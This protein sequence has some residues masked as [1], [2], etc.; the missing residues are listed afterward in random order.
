MELPKVPTDNLYKFMALSGIVLL[1]ASAFPRY[2]QA[3][4]EFELIRAQGE[5]R[6]GIKKKDWASAD[7][8][9][10]LTKS[11]KLKEETSKW[12]EAKDLAAAEPQLI[13]KKRQEIRT[14]AYEIKAV[15]T[16]IR[17]LYRD[18]EIAAIEVKTKEKE[19]S[20]RLDVIRRL[21]YVIAGG[22]WVGAILSVSGFLLWYHKLQKYQDKIVKKQA[23][24]N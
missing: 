13:E 3:K 8:D 18:S 14:D 12:K 10:L 5:K 1:V 2:W 23:T 11:N 4:L 16:E 20:Q 22:K 24:D 6:K 9:Y 21:K 7:V 19:I 15:N 17:R